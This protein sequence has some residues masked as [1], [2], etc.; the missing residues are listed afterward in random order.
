MWKHFD[1][2]GEVYAV[3]D[4]RAVSPSNHAERRPIDQSRPANDQIV[5]AS[6]LEVLWRVSVIHIYYRRTI[7]T[8][9]RSL[10]DCQSLS[11]SHFLLT[12]VI[13]ISLIVF[14]NLS[15]NNTIFF[16][17]FSNKKIMQYFA[18]IKAR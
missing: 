12:I 3:Y 9:P 13:V 11:C 15:R 1:M 8:S 18:E 17:C 2:R 4:E 14:I 7:D 6:R 16:S 5:T 10:T